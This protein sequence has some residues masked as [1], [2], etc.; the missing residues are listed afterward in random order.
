MGAFRVGVAALRQA[1]R[2]VA[3]VEAHHPEL[4]PIRLVGATEGLVRLVLTYYAV[5]EADAG[6]GL[7]AGTANVSLAREGNEGQGWLPTNLLS[8]NVAWAIAA[9]DTLLDMHVETGCVTFN[10]R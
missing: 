2:Q 4:Q 8:P 10:P 7:L 9:A 3:W 1:E 5:S 6:V